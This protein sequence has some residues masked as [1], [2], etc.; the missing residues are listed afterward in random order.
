MR[1]SN[2]LAVILFVSL[3]A[4]GLLAATLPELEALPAAVTNS[5]I[6]A[7]KMKGQLFLFS[8]M[9]MGEKKSW[10]GT[11]NSVY[12]VSIEGGEWTELRSV[13]GPIGRLG[14][15]A[16]GSDGKIFLFGGYVLDSQGGAITIPDTNVLSVSANRWYRGGD[17]PVPVH[18]FVVG[19]YRERYVYLIGGWSKTDAVRDVQIYDTE[20]DNWL[21]ATPLAGSAVYGHA[22]ALVGDTIVYVDGAQRNPAGGNPGFVT[23]DECW[24]GKIDHHDPTKIAWSKLPAHP[25]PARFRIS[26][27]GLEK[28]DRVYFASGSSTPYDFKGVGYD[29]KPAEATP[30]VFDYNIRAAKW[31]T[32]NQ[33]AADLLMDQSALVAAPQGLVLVGGMEKGQKVTARV[34]ALPRQGK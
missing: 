21:K 17:I 3:L 33:N 26:A 27:G 31:E 8:L 4:A 5:A 29:G 25:G 2:I 20:K 34:K 30:V 7:M 12:A 6:T 13:P 1:K 22:G 18:D 24:M 23:T 10:N 11:T 16:V 14:A 15:S 19:L 28:E 32:V 9:G